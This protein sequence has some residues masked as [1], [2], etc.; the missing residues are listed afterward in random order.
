[1]LMLPRNW[2]SCKFWNFTFSLL[3]NFCHQLKQKLEQ[4]ILLRIACITFGELLVLKI[5]F[6]LSSADSVNS[7]HGH[8]HICIYAAHRRRKNF[9]EQ[10]FRILCEH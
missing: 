4:T 1:M 2:V 3:F 9:G 6:Q 7:L 8:G 5:Y 10:F